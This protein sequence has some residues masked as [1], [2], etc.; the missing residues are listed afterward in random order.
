[1][2]WDASQAFQNNRYDAAIKSALTASGATK[3]T[4]PKATTSAP[5]EKASDDDSKTFRFAR[6]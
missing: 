3:K 6:N 5:K 4:T 2:L 1:M